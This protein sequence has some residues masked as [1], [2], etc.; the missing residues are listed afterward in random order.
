MKRLWVPFLVLFAVGCTSH[1]V[2]P[3]HKGRVFDKTGL[4]A[5][6]AGGV[7]FTGPILNPGTIMTGPY[8]DVRLVECTQKTT[9]ETM[10][11]MTKDGVQFGLDM[12]V[13][14]G[15]NCDDVKAVEYLL[16]NLVPSVDAQHPNNETITSEQL[17]GVYIRPALGEAVRESISPYIANDVNGEREKIFEDVRKRFQAMMGRQKPAPVLVG[18][19]NLSNMTYPDEMAHA[20]VDRATQ[21][22]LKDKAIAERE[23]VTAEVET[24]KMRRELA[25]TEADNDVTRIVAIGKALHANQ[26]YLQYDAQQRWNDIYFHAG[27]KGNLIIAAPSPTQL[28]PL[29]K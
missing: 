18:D 4:W 12:Y 29:K 21:A 13:R 2:P 17:Y 23:R 8:P 15:A 24:T 7:G 3:A 25:V 10:T 6:Y 5:F 19:L 11:A 16:G 1:E 26:E 9:K 14:Y 27:E 22:V 28:L 20:N